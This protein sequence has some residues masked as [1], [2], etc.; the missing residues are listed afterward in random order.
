MILHPT[1]FSI[2][3]D[4]MSLEDFY[5]KFCGICEEIDLSEPITTNVVAIKKYRESMPVA[6]FLSALPSSFDGSRSHILGAK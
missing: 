6:C 5:G 1:F 3:L 2:S 4:D